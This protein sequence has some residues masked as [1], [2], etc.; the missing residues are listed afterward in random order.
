MSLSRQHLKEIVENAWTFV[1]SV[2]PFPL[3]A[4]DAPEVR[5]LSPDLRVGEG[6]YLL[7]QCNVNAVPKARFYWMKDK[8]NLTLTSQISD[9]R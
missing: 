2:F 1:I 4:A 6:K 5:T 7:L 9:N 3:F 8:R